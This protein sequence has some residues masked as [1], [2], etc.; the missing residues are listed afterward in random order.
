MKVH[1]PGAR[2][3]GGL[4]VATALVTACPSTALAGTPDG[5]SSPVSAE[6]TPGDTHDR[7]AER[8]KAARAAAVRAAIERTEPERAAG[9]PERWGQVVE[10]PFGAAATGEG[11]TD[12]GLAPW[13]ARGALEIAGAAAVVAVQVRRRMP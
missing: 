10:V 2:F 4:A 3:L 13:I 5:G 11:P 6:P 9:H 1:L 12:D 8:A 7:A